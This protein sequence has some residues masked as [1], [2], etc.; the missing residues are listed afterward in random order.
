MVPWGGGADEYVL[1]GHHC[2]GR[3]DLPDRGLLRFV[4]T[5]AAALNGAELLLPWAP[6]CDIT[7][8]FFFLNPALCRPFV[9]RFVSSSP[10]PS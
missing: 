8:A 7:T 3:N 5:G 6:H 10:D 1:R 9:S 4:G 2:C